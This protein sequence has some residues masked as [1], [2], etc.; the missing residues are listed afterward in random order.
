[1]PWRERFGEQSARQA[2]ELPPAAREAGHFKVAATVA[3]LKKDP[4]LDPLRKRADL[5][6]F[7]ANLTKFDK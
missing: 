2:V 6:A 5:K 4:D 1:M 3:H 7:L